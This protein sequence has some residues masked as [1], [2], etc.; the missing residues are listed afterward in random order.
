MSHK[1]LPPAYSPE[2]LTWPPPG[3]VRQTA[4]RAPARPA[5]QIITPPYIFHVLKLAYHD[6]FLRG[7]PLPALEFASPRRDM[8]LISQSPRAPLACSSL[9]QQANGD[10]VSTFS[11]ERPMFRRTR[12]VYRSTYPS[13]SYAK[14]NISLHPCSRWIFKYFVHDRA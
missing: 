14:T 5:S 4:I 3:K 7:I 2:P 12:N 9:S 11:R 1:R 10:P 8:T 6:A 13:R